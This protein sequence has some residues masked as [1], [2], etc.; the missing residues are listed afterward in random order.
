[1]D[2]NPSR[3]PSPLTRLFHNVL[4]YLGINRGPDSAEEFE[5]EIQ[6]LLDDGEEHGLISSREGKMIN[7]ILEFRDTV[8][9][10][11]MT[12]SSEMVRVEAE[13]P[14]H[15]L[16]QLIIEKGFSR[17]PVYAGSQDNIIGILYAKDL[18]K[19]LND[20]QLPKA[21]DIAKPAY[22]ALENQKIIY[23][24][25][26]FQ[27]KKVH[28]AIIT[29]EFGSV[30]GLASLEDVLEEIVGEITDESDQPVTGWQVLDQNT[31]LA[32]AKT[33]LEEVEE[34]F[35][36]ELPEGPYESIGG[37]MIH[38]LGHLPDASTTI[39]IDGLDFQVLSATKRRIIQVKISRSRSQG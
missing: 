31:I 22:F 25:R 8:A 2:K 21:G 27:A 23:L 14:Y 11:I 9:R 35:G 36:L 18:L 16:V 20:P 17:I 15:D 12:P 29:D 10:E 39:R 24:L 6:E 34:Y 7:S 4:D 30:R 1:M 37:L 38:Q 33:D 3:P 13:T 32:D 26:D 5:H 19:H 28:L